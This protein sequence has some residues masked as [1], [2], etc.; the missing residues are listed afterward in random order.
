MAGI[1]QV[2]GMEGGRDRRGMLSLAYSYLVLDMSPEEASLV[3]LPVKPATIPETG[4]RKFKEW[5]HNRNFMMTAQF[6]G[7]VSEPGEEAEQC[8]IQGEWR[9][10]P[11]EAFPDREALMKEFGAYEDPDTGRLKFPE[12]LEGTTSSGSSL[13][14]S[15]RQSEKNPLFGLTTYPV[16]RMVASRAYMRFNVP[17]S[18]YESVGEVTKTLPAVFDEPPNKTWIKDPPLVRKRGNAWEIVERWKD[19]ERLKHIEALYLLLGKR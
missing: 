12:T 19:V 8:M 14:K 13:S 1:I 15:K 16:Q 17:S 5:V 2:K 3:A 11:I 4:E 18:V 7:I 9:E 6:E 10:E